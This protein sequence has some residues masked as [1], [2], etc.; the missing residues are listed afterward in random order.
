MPSN[1]Q[2]LVSENDSRD[3]GLVIL[4]ERAKLTISRDLWVSRDCAAEEKFVSEII[5]AGDR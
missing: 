1:L 4:S 3:G 2:E 5:S